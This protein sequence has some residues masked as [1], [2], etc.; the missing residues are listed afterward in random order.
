MKKTRLQKSHATVPLTKTALGSQEIIIPGFL[1][2]NMMTGG[3]I[4]LITPRNIVDS[5][6]KIIF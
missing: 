2:R 1:E 4:I 5:W 6:E 3:V